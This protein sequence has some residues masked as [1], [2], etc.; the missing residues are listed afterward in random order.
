MSTILVQGAM[1]EEIELLAR[2][3]PGGRWTEQKGYSFYETGA[4]RSENHSC[5]DAGRNPSRLYFD[6]AWDRRL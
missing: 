5:A 3:L 6:N 1:Q 2:M 4:A